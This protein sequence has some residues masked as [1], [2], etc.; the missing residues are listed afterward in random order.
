MGSADRSPSARPCRPA[1]VFDFRPR[2]PRG[3]A[4]AR[5]GGEVL[6][7][8][9]NGSSCP[10]AAVPTENTGR[11]ASDGDMMRSPKGLTAP[12][13]SIARRWLGRPITVSSDADRFHGLGAASEPYSGGAER[14]GRWLLKAIEDNRPEMAIRIAAMQPA[15]KL[16]T[17][18]P[19][20]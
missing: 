10:K 3:R 18:A 7:H 6:A 14:D 5:A 20:D 4:R 9:R 8:R 12:A 19:F 11:A 16:V 17:A 15:M 1:T 13:H 2:L